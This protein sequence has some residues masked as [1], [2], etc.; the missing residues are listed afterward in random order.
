MDDLAVSITPAMIRAGE[1]TLENFGA[2]FP[3][4]DLVKAIY[5]AMEAARCSTTALPLIPQGAD[6]KGVR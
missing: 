2:T 5:I 4:D 3:D 1:R 6:P